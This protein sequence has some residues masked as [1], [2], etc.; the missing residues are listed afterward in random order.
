[1]QLLPHSLTAVRSFNAAA[2][3]LSCSRAAEELSLSPG[4]VSKHVL[5]LEEYLGVKLFRRVHQGLVLTSAGT[6]YWESIKPALSM[7]EEATS[8]AR[9]L[10]FEQSTDLHLKV[11][12]TFG[13]K[14][15]MPRLPAFTRL[16]PD[17]H[18][19]F[20]P[21]ATSTIGQA[22][23]SAEIRAGRGAWDGMH[24]HYLTGRNVVLVCSASLAGRMQDWSASELLK[25]RLLEHVRHP[26]LWSKWLSIQRVD[27]CGARITQKYEQYSV[28]I[29]ALRASLGI[30]FVPRCLI[31]EELQAGKLTQLSGPPVATGVG[32]YLVYPKERSRMSALMRFR[33]WLAAEAAEYEAR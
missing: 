8:R 4:A 9:M 6:T 14:W 21:S 22:T 16:Q 5:S 31:D 28:M 24:A 33:D 12:N 17:I 10:A 15:L 25:G 13:E 29:S 30:G 11:P 3:H 27:T 19:Q 18:V 23:F 7:L 20:A 1:M 32:Y 26:N 2:K